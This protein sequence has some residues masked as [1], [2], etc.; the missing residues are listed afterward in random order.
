M[1]DPV[2]VRRPAPGRRRAALAA[3]ARAV[4]RAPVT[5]RTRRDLLFCLISV[6]LGVAGFALTVLLLVPGF[7]AVDLGAWARCS[8][9]RW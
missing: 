8:G 6:P 9:C 1:G 3:G 7:I 4:A 5:R 2:P